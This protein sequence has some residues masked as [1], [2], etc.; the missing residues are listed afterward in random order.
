MATT[1]ELTVELKLDAEQVAAFMARVDRLEQAFVNF[2]SSVGA[3]DQY[4][5]A[6]ADLGLAPPAPAATGGGFQQKVGR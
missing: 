5:A 1:D 3:P 4:R 2:A 6:L